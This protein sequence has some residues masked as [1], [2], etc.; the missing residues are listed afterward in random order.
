MSPLFSSFLSASPPFNHT[1]ELDNSG[2]HSVQTWAK[3]GG[4]DAAAWGPIDPDTV[5]NITLTY[6]LTK[7]LLQFLFGFYSDR[8][9]RRQLVV[10][11]LALISLGQIAYAV[12]GGTAATTAAAETGSFV[13]SFALGLGTAMM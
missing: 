11:G 6:D 2:Q 3:A 9:G 13:C 4:G 1:P 10:G 8:F 7:G 5:T 12:V